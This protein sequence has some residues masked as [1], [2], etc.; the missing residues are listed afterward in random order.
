MLAR[1]HKALA[2]PSKSAGSTISARRAAASI[3]KK[4]KN[5]PNTE[6]RR[7]KRMSHSF[8]RNEASTP[9]RFSP[10]SITR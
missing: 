2:A 8:W 7:K 3:K 10:Y 1:C 4:Y 6:R 9:A 5:R